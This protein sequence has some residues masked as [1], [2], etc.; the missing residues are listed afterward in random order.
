MEGS[1][2]FV[3]FRMTR[4]IDPLALSCHFVLWGFNHVA[5]HYSKLYIA[6]RIY[7]AIRGRRDTLLGTLK[8]Y[9]SFPLFFQLTQK[10]HTYFIATISFTDTFFYLLYF[11]VINLLT[12]Y[13]LIPY[14]KYVMTLVTF[15]ILMLNGVPQKQ[16]DILSRTYC[17][18]RLLIW[19]L[20]YTLQY[21]YR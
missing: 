16:E 17:E 6:A 13:F 12:Y 7:L 18:K 2:S 4:I 14:K 1:L 3:L 9:T 21:V 5:K 15:F 10:S 20:I 11:K 8:H 19:Q